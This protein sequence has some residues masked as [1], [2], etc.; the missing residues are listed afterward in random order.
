MIEPDP[1]LGP[2]APRSTLPDLIFRV[3]YELRDGRHQ[4]TYTLVFRV[5]PPEGNL[6]EFGPVVLD[7]EPGAFFHSLFEDIRNLSRDA[8]TPAE[9]ARRLAGKGARLFEELLPE[10]LQRRF[11]QLRGTVR[12][13]Q[14]LS[15]EPW[16]PWELLKFRERD[17]EPGRFFGEAFALTRWL[18][19]VPDAPRLP[20]RRMAL[21]VPHDSNLPHA[22]P[23]RRFLL[24]QQVDGRRVDEIAARTDPVVEALAQGGY[25]GW[26]FTGHASTPANDPQRAWLG[27][28]QNDEL[29]PDDIYERAKLF[30]Q[31]PL[32]FLNGCQ[33]ARAGFSLTGLGGWAHDFFHAGAGAFLGTYWAVRDEPALC[34]SQAFYGALFAG[35]A[36]GEAVRTARLE[37]RDRFPGDPSWLA[38]T[39]FANPLATYPAPA[40]IERL[41]PFVQD[42]PPGIRQKIRS[43]AQLLSEE[44]DGFVGRTW[45][46]SEIDRFLSE[47]PHGVFLLQG[48]PG[49]GKSS[50]MAELVRRHGWV[51]HFNIRAQGLQSAADF[52]ANVCAQLIAAYRLNWTSLPPEATTNGHFFLEVLDKV[53]AGLGPGEKAT[54]VVDAL[55]EAVR[56]PS[57][58]DANLLFLPR[59]LPPGIHLILSSRPGG[60]PLLLDF[61]PRTF[62]I[63]QND[64][65]NLHDIRELLSRR[66]SPGLLAWAGE[67]RLEAVDFIEKMVERSQGNFM[68]LRHVLP[69]IEAGTYQDLHFDQ[70]PKGLARYYEDHWRRIKARDEEAWFAWKLPVL[71]ALTV[72]QEPISLRLVAR[73]AG[74]EDTRRVQ[75]VLDQW[76][77]FLYQTETEDP[78]S[79]KRQ[80][81]YRLYHASFQEFIAAKDEVKEE[82]VRLKDRNGQIADLLWE[83]LFGAEG[84]EGAEED[85]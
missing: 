51:H 1:A 85:T 54:L 71:E 63:R 83:D 62:E 35:V 36:A 57:A 13:V 55:D 38:Y 59:R 72:V 16:I 14:I 75:A 53:S 79:G 44:A 69:E 28:E 40:E 76:R 9:L 4:F 50:V 82:R 64:R 65:D 60:S 70:L 33:T 37:V 73:F 67:Q 26:H 68:Y 32:I 18:R 2:A 22:E 11:E 23:E 30:G 7:K 74:V 56:D 12:T 39:L 15:D 8:Q 17:G 84:G 80:K 20:L 49:I 42:A 45:V 41:M 58:P 31:R 78:E 66:L 27:L 5:A 52:L 21:V 6:E 61:E 48:E 24:T 25:D 19:K 81:R 47:T 3:R 43:F 10:P 77:E 46:L 29:R 34:F